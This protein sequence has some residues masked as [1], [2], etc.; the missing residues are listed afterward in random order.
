MNIKTDHR[1][2]ISPFTQVQ[3]CTVLNDSIVI[4]FTEAGESVELVFNSSAL[5]V[6]EDLIKSAQDCQKKLAEI[7]RQ[8]KHLGF[9]LNSSDFWNR[10]TQSV[11]SDVIEEE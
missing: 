10:S 4:T 7:K 5:S 3:G 1:V 2:I 11:C 9:E 6:V 8:Q